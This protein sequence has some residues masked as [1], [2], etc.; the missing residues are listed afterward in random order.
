LSSDRR[1]ISIRSRLFYWSAFAFAI[2]LFA[3]LLDT[4][5]FSAAL[6]LLSLRGLSILW[7]LL[8]YLAVVAL[9]TAAWSSRSRLDGCCTFGWQ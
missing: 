6:A 5:Q 7:A 8:P 3:W 2:L 1:T 9:E 4:S